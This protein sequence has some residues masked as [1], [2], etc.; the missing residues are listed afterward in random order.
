M[1][2]TKTFKCTF[3]LSRASCLDLRYTFPRCQST[4]AST[5]GA[6]DHEAVEYCRDFVRKYDYEAYLIAQ[7][8]PK[9]LRGSYYAIKAFSTELAMIQD[10]VSNPT[11]GMMRMQFWRDAIKAMMNGNPSRHPIAQALHQASIRS[12]LPFYHLNRIIDAR[13]AE[14]QVPVHLTVDSLTA[15]SESTSSTLLYLLL[16]SLSL[17]SSALSH[18][19]SHLGAAQAFTTLI[20]AMPFHAKNGRMV[21]PA[22]ITAKHG[23]VQEEVFRRGPAAKGI[24]DAVFE[25]ATL[26]NDHLVTARSMFDQ[27]GFG[28]RVPQEAMPVFL[29]GV[30]VSS[31]LKQAE[32]VNFNIFNPRM[33]TR[34]WKLPWRIWKGYYQR[35]F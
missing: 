2:S 13:D 30:P 27:E 18:A 29:T 31:I 26:A 14:L 9:E 15:H 21:V 16:S 7:F 11:I 28:G 5:A 19:A 32:E 22:E 20:R 12:N 35:M 10:S 3:N 6:T 34:D 24:D 1:L 17:P 25:F 33:Q 8:W 23:V 4:F